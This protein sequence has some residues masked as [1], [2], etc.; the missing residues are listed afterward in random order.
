MNA[1]E[2]FD[3]GVYKIDDI[4]W[5]EI[6]KIDGKI[7]QGR[8]HISTGGTHTKTDRNSELKCRF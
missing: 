8:L 2:F 1:T 3:L 7:M 4:L 5:G 6:M